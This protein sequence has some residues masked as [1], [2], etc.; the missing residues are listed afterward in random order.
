MRCRGYFAVLSVLLGPAP[1]V[2]GGSHYSL[3]ARIL[4]AWTAVASVCTGAPWPTGPKAATV[5]IVLSGPEVC[6]ILAQQG[7]G[8][9]KCGS[10]AFTLSYK[11]PAYITLDDAVQALDIGLSRRRHDVR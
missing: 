7:R 6:D 2:Q 10:E 11:H 4:A 8:L 9:Y 5:P 3:V 1:V